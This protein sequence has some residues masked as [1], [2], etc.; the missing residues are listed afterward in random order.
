MHKGNRL[1]FSEQKNIIIATLFYIFQ[2]AVIRFSKNSGRIFLTPVNSTVKLTTQKI[3]QIVTLVDTVLFIVMFWKPGRCFYRSYAIAH[4]LRQYG[5]PLKIN[6]GWEN[7]HEFKGKARAHCWLTLNDMPF[8]EKNNPFD[9]FPSKF[10][11]HNEDIQYWL[12]SDGLSL[13]Q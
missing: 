6:L 12:G 1:S 2:A 5:V 13:S 7:I 11:N 4:I 10:E 9:R 8:A 3:N